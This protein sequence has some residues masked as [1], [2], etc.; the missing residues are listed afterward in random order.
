MCVS[1]P[2][3]SMIVDIGGGTTEVAVISLA[4]MVTAE[5]LRVG[6]DELDHSIIQYVKQEY[7]VLIGENTAEAVKLQIGNCVE[8]EE[9]LRMH[10]R[11]RDL[12][13]GMPPGI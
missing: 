2:V 1:E 13:T 3:G 10:I 4:G 11:G 8:P 12:Q 9:E 6:G 7:N 5:S